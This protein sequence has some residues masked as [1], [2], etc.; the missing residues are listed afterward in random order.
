MQ[1]SG[2]LTVEDGVPKLEG[3]R[4]AVKIAEDQLGAASEIID[5]FG[6]SEGG[7]VRVKGTLG[8]VGAVRVLFVARVEKLL[9]AAADDLGGIPIPVPANVKCK[10]CGYLN[11]VPF[12]DIHH[13]EG[14][15]NPDPPPHPLK[16]F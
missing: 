5:S 15:Q 14:C 11:T 9:M 1:K 7:G 13:P 3:I 12:V 2:I 6:L 4:L 8:K 10:Q 16:V